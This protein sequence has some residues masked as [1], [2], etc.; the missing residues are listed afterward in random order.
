VTL[1]MACW[2]DV[3]DVKLFADDIFQLSWPRGYVCY[4][5]DERTVDRL[6]GDAL[7][8]FRAASDVWARAPPDGVWKRVQGVWRPDGTGHEQWV[9]VSSRGD[10]VVALTIRSVDEFRPGDASP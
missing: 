7:A 1:Y 10:E 2:A 9:F 5:H 8:A 3:Q 6:K 4:D